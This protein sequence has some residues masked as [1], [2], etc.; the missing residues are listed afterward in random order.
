M[1]FGFTPRQFLDVVQS[2]EYKFKDYSKGDHLQRKGEE[3]E[4]LHLLLEGVRCRHSEPGAYVR[5]S[6]LTLVHVPAAAGGH[7][8]V[9]RRRDGYRAQATPRRHSTSAAWHR[10]SKR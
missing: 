4:W 6:K 9:G 5:A 3:M 7:V 8:R 2:A 10:I 1:R